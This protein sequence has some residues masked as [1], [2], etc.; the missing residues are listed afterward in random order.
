MELMDS[1][2]IER[3]GF[4]SIEERVRPISDCG[5]RL[6][7]ER[8]AFVRGRESEWDADRQYVRRLERILAEVGRMGEIETWLR[9]LPDIRPFLSSLAPDVP[10]GA[11]QA[12]RFKRFAVCAREIGAALDRA[13]VHEGCDRVE[14]SLA[15]D[16]MDLCRVLQP[17]GELTAAFSLEDAGDW[18]YVRASAWLRRARQ[19]RVREEREAMRSIGEAL[20]AVPKSRRTVAILE[21]DETALALA[22]SE[23]RLRLCGRDGREVLFEVSLP[24]DDGAAVR[25]RAAAERVG[26]LEGALLLR[27]GRTL[28]ERSDQIRDVEAAVARVD[29]AL[30]RIRCARRDGFSWTERA[31]SDVTLVEGRPAD[32]PEFTPVTFR[33]TE[34]CTVLTGPNMGGKTAAQVTLLQAL[35]CHHYGYPAP[36][37]ALSA[38]LF[39][40]LA[41]V[42]GD[43]LPLV[44]GLSSFGAEVD[45]VRKIWSHPAPFACVDEFGRSTHPEIGRALAEGLVRAFFERGAGRL[46]LATH[47][48]LPPDRRFGRLRVRGLRAGSPPRAGTAKDLAGHLRG[49]MDYRIEPAGPSGGDEE[50]NGL[51]IAQWLGIPEG[52]LAW[53]RAALRADRAQ[54]RGGEQNVQA[55]SGSGDD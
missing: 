46:L 48:E 30:V 34:R 37:A 17:G 23:R 47:F 55:V 36:A 19:E 20:G 2:T 40:R 54:E 29:D 27:L 12:A 25:E 52:I 21:D 24:P 41:F 44:D 53:A 4:L 33:L 22:A 14:P 13:A 9:R 32:H 3:I 15:M 42:G 31:R 45:A 38:P 26:E 16:G 6:R 50:R 5:Q 11:E 49:A 43:P 35:A 39:S 28:W 7:V 10:I 1:W 51:L 8:G 18:E